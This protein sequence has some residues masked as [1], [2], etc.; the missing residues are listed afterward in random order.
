MQGSVICLRTET[1]ELKV[2]NINFLNNEFKM[3]CF[4]SFDSHELNDYWL[5]SCGECLIIQDMSNCLKVI[6][7]ANGKIV[8]E[9]PVFNAV[10]GFFTKGDLIVTALDNGNL[11]SFLI[12]KDVKCK[13]NETAKKILNA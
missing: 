5:S 11:A 4:G 7:I 3:D 10:K 9:L 2:Q 13:K 12:I 1:D 6:E 8:A